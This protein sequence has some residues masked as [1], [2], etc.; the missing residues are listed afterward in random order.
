M[1]CVLIRR[2]LIY[3]CARASLRRRLLPLKPSQA[4]LVNRALREARS[5]RNLLLL[6][7]ASTSATDHAA[8]SAPSPSLLFR[9]IPSP[10]IPSGPGPSSSS[11]ATPRLCCRREIISGLTA[12]C[13]DRCVM[14]VAP[15]AADATGRYCSARGKVL[16]SQ[17]KGTGGD[18]TVEVLCVKVVQ[19]PL[20]DF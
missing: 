13:R 9:P 6:L 15:P 2:S 17:G 14:T 20:I 19:L 10:K 5:R 1:L 8:A 7:V 11:F 18:D 3:V 12:G 4:I 16:L